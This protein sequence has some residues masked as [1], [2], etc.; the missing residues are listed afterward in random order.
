MASCLKL[1]NH[2]LNQCCPDWDSQTN[3]TENELETVAKQQS[4]IEHKVFEIFFHNFLR[5]N[6]LNH[7][8]KTS[9][10]P[11]HKYG[12]IVLIETTEI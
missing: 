10:S 3:F 1:P 5:E 11:Q 8:C 9:L 7:M 12:G 2:N 6:E 4:T